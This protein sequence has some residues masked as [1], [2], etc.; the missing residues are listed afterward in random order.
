[1]MQWQKNETILVI[2]LNKVDFRSCSDAVPEVIFLYIG[3][4][5]R[6]TAIIEID[7]RGEVTIALCD[8]LVLL[9]AK[10][11]EECALMLFFHDMLCTAEY[12]LRIL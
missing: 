6:A 9:I 8:F 11:A 10:V 3:G 5:H 7:K 1:M 4:Q 12:A 2:F